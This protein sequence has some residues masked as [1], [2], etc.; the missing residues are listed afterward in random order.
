VA[1]AHGNRPLPPLPL[2]RTG[3]VLV[4]RRMPGWQTDTPVSL[5]SPTP[6]MPVPSAVFTLAFRGILSTIQRVVGG[7]AIESWVESE[8]QPPLHEPKAAGEPASVGE[9]CRGV[10]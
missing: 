6:L 3:R 10:A 4:P 5:G 9:Q 7:A 1:K 2:G 8:T